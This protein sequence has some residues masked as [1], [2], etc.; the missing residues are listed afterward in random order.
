M[1][2]AARRVTDAPS[3]PDDT[4]RAAAG[5]V[6]VGGHRTGRKGSLNAVNVER[7]K[8]KYNRPFKRID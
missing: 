8:K 1:E 7:A 6:G 4:A 5:S 2:D 3:R